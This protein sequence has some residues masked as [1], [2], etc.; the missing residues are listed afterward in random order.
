MPLAIKLEPAAPIY[1][2]YMAPLI[3]SSLGRLSYG[4][5]MSWKK[6]RKSQKIAMGQLDR[7][8]HSQYRV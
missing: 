3:A 1:A 5:R 4:V 7:L 8:W 6:V 2:Q